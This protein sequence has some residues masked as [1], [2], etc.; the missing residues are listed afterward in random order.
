[1][2][3]SLKRKE[4]VQESLRR[5]AYEL[6][7]RASRDL[8]GV[9]PAVAHHRVRKGCK[10]MRASLRLVRQPLAAQFDEENRW[11]RDFARQLA[12]PRDAQ[13]VIESW[14]DLVKQAR[15]SRLDEID[16]R[17]LALLADRRDAVTEQRAPE[18]AQLI[19]QLGAARARVGDWKLDRTG[20]DAIA[21]GLA[22][23]YR[24]ARTR[25]DQARRRADPAVLHEWRKRVKDHWYHM[26]I[27]QCVWPD[28][29]GARA[30][31]LDRLAEDLGR[32][33]DLDLLHAAIAGLGLARS[34][35]RPIYE[36]IATRAATIRVTA[37][38]HGAHLFAERPKRF[39]NRMRDH[40]A[41]WKSES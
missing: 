40:Y 28:E 20:F 7:D 8:A 26:R 35:T 21:D 12:G 13:A 37:F 5:I 27:V 41:I 32:C 34:E 39:T 2:A 22:A 14:N 38:A 1:M 9:P 17:V 6:I 18:T 11:Y 36:L 19:E 4:S 31:A 23:A 15:P 29:L 10:K 25:Q 3:Y 24:K 16:R 33:H 30:A